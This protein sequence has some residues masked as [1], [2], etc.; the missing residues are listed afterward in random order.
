MSDFWLVFI[1][2][3][4]VYLVYDREKDKKKVVK[5]NS[6]INDSLMDFVGEYC[7]IDLKEW[8]VSLDDCYEINGFIKEMDDEWVLIETIKKEKAR[9]III[10][11]SL[12]NSIK[13]VK[14]KV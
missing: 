14:Q 12:I 8:L 2:G 6:H 5:K 3:L 10:R 9:T 11:K 1:A 13:I 7:E 4:L